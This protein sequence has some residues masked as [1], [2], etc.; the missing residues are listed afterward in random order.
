M[1]IYEPMH[2]YIFNP[3]LKFS[4]TVKLV[5]QFY[6]LKYL[7]SD[8]FESRPHA[9]ITQCRAEVLNTEGGSLEFVYKM[10]PVEKLKE[11]NNISSMP[12][13]Q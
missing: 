1:S 9:H 5:S 11:E 2:I 10:L 13:R 3:L 12:M 4:K 8:P 6:Y 7:L